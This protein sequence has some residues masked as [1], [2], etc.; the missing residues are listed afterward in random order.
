MLG[1]TVFD[2]VLALNMFGTK[3]VLLICVVGFMTGRT[4]FLD[5]AL[6]YSL[7]N[8]IGMVALLRF[9]EYGSFGGGCGM[10]I[11]ID[12]VSVCISWSGSFFS[13]IG[14]IGIVRLPEF[15]SRMHGGGITDT[16]GAGMIMIGLMFQGGLSLVTV[17]LLM[18]LFFL[19][20]TS[21]SS[22][23]ALAKSAMSHGLKPVLDTVERR[24]PGRE[25][26]LIVFAI[27]ALLAATAVTVA[28]IRNLWAAVM[29]TGIYSFL[30]ASWM[31]ILDAPDVAFTEAAVGAGISTVLMLATLSLTGKKE[32][33]RTTKTP[34]SPLLVV[35][36]T[37][38]ALVYGTLRH[39]PF[40][41][42]NAPIQEYPNPSFIEKSQA[43]MHGMPNVVTTV[44]ASYRGYD[45]LG[46]RP[47]S[48]TAGIAV[49]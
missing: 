6:L 27:L 17:K 2:R 36:I 37:G 33:E 4:D 31:L 8:F 15:F 1:P 29:F 11:L 43:D 5:L 46:R 16:M 14:G 22:C 47:L 30:S 10:T 39:A 21:P 9:T 45:T 25:M 41:R 23:H 40:R 20:V 44:L 42:S 38:C 24:R 28:R 26:N 7:M 12:L 34:F 18:I 32:I 13:I 19:M 48:F 35:T 3:T 49:C